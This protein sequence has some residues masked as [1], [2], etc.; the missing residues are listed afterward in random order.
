M[1]YENDEIKA[2]V[3]LITLLKLD[4]NTA[5]L[6]K[7]SQ[8]TSGVTEDQI[9][10]FGANEGISS[11]LLDAF[12]EFRL[13]VTGQEVMDKFNIRT[14]PEVGETKKRLETDIFKKILGLS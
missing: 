2:I 1:S 11:Q 10:N 13:S 14:G 6:L 3:F 9:R 7:K 4:V 8:E 5:Y 12:E